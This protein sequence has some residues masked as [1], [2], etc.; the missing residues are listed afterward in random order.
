[1]T[2]AEVL[3]RGW[4]SDAPYKNIRSASY[5]TPQSPTTKQPW[6]ISTTPHSVF[7]LGR[8]SPVIF[9][10]SSTPVSFH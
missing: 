5:L 6:Y 8:Y 2:L 9:Q 10:L 1:M 3:V 4:L 7:Q